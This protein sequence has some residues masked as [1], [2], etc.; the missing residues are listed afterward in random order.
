MEKNY[1]LRTKLQTSEVFYTPRVQINIE[2]FYFS[3]V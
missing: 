2:Q 3:C 1:Y